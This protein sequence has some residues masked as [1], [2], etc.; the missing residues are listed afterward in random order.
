MLKDDWTDQTSE[1]IDTE[2]IRPHQR[3]SAVYNNTKGE[4]YL[5]FSTSREQSKQDLITTDLNLAGQL[6]KSN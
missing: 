4:K 1:N 6:I 3:P 2:Q 5:S